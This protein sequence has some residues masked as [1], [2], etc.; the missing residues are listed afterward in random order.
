MSNTGT[1]EPI[2]TGSQ[3]SVALSG[4]DLTSLL[5]KGVNQG[6]SEP[7]EEAPEPEEAEVQAE[8]PEEETVEAEREPEESPGGIDLSGLSDEQLKDLSERLGGR[9]GSE[10]G[11]M[12]A[13]IRELKAEREIEA[14]KRS[15]FDKE[16]SAPN[17][18]AR[19]TSIKSLE[20][21]YDT[22]AAVIKAGERILRR[23]RDAEPDDEV[24]FEG[25]TYTISQ[26]EEMVDNAREARETHIPNRVRQLQK[27]EGL[28]AA[29]VRNFDEVKK[30]HAWLAE[31]GE[32]RAAFDQVRDKYLPSVRDHIPDILPYFDTMLAD[33]FAAVQQR[34]NPQKETG[35]KRQAKQPKEKPPGSPGGSAA[36]SGRPASSTEKRSK[37]LQDFSSS[38]RSMSG[39]DLEQFLATK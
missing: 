11:R 27:T 20:Q 7:E 19:E 6:E 31:G 37:M 12:R 24:E 38:G 4:D 36:P 9:L 8:S 14:D 16:E 34:Q 39:Q 33:H 3:E 15:P 21:T 28:E 26:I 17:P 32:L 5:Q 25:S 10:I 2:A 29:R 35:I 13:E 18:Y 30:M 22:A 1:A 23:N